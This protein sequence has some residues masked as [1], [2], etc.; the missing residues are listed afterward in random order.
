MKADAIWGAGVDKTAQ[1]AD[2]SLTFFPGQHQALPHLLC[3]PGLY[4][5]AKLLSLQH[6]STYFHHSHFIGS[7]LQKNIRINI[8]MLS[9]PVETIK[10]PQLNWLFERVVVVGS[11]PNFEAADNACQWSGWF[12][13]TLLDFTACRQA[14]SETQHWTALSMSSSSK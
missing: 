14:Q 11:K 6:I 3:P 8:S 1:C 5:S 10:P 12:A 4:F 13:H 7:Q 9:F 2:A